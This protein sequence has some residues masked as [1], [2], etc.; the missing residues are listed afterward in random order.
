M[1]SSVEASN[2]GKAGAAG[3]TTA[4]AIQGALELG[5]LRAAPLHSD[6]YPF[7]IA[8]GALRPAALPALRRD[9]PM[10]RQTGFHPT[11][12]FTPEGAF[13]ALL[14]ELEGPEIATVLSEKL[15][16]DLAGLPRLITV[17]RLSAAH[18]GRIHTDSASKVATLL[19][20]L[21]EGWSAPNGRLRILRGPGS[22]EDY[23]AEVSPQEGNMLAFLRSDHSWHGHTPF[24]GERR[25][26]QVAWLRDASELERKRRRHG[27]SHFLRRLM[28][29]EQ[30]A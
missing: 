16:V 23:V 18:E 24:V 14:R 17:R 26:V 30:R 12:S 2:I 1:I 15:G 6:P 8:H 27:L 22:F 4:P 9:F 5:R 7:V 10:L 3:E 20:Y 28:G 25:V 21:H 11:D 29:R 13:A 19:L